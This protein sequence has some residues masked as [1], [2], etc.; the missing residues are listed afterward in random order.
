MIFD[1]IDFE[2]LRLINISRYLPL[3]LKKNYDSLMFERSVRTNLQVHRLIKIDSTGRCFKLT[4]RGRECL[5]EM[6]VEVIKDERRKLDEELFMRR[7]QNALW[8]VVLTLAGTD[9][10]YN[11]CRELA[12]TECG[13]VSSLCLRK[14]DAMKVLAG[15]KFLGIL[16]IY[17]TA[18][19]SYYLD[20]SSWIYPSYEKDTY[21]SQIQSV[22][23]IEESKILLAGKTLEELWQILTADYERTEV[24]KGMKPFSIA[25]EE[26][27]SEHLLVPL[28]RNGVLQMSVLKIWRNRER[29]KKEIG[30]IKNTVSSI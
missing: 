18:Y 19:V 11:S 20:K 27:G 26:L 25:L 21:S 16:K 24:K 15:T 30:C 14:N 3:N 9:I 8:N 2:L 29:I 5:A 1:T 7:F 12:D 6:G 28:G 4:K 13:Y 23:N 10:Y 22:R 17:D